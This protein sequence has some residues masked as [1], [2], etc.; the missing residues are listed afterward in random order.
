MKYV[1]K[2]RGEFE[3]TQEVEAK[4]E[5]QARKMLAENAG[6]DIESIATETLEILSIEEVE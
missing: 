5:E 1:G 2:L 4:S 3:L 6:K